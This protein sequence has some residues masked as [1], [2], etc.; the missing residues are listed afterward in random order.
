MHKN[1]GERFGSLRLPV[2]MTKDLDAGLDFDQALLGRRHMK[3][4]LDQEAG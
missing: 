2:A 3:A 1:N 4:P